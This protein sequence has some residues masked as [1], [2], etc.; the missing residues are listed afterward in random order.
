[1]DGGPPS[2]EQECPTTTLNLLRLQLHNSTQHNVPVE[3]LSLEPGST[4]LTNIKRKVVELA[5]HSN[6]LDTIQTSAQS[7]GPGVGMDNIA[8]HS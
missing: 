2:Q 1:M 4:L 7:P 6:V 8:A 5:T 3:S